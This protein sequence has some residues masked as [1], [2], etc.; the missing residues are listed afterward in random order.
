MLPE[1]LNMELA[2]DYGIIPFEVATHLNWRCQCGWAYVIDQKRTHR[3][4]SNPCCPYHMAERAVEIYKKF[5]YKGIGP[6]TCLNYIL[7]NKLTSHFDLLDESLYLN[8][9]SVIGQSM[10]KYAR[11][12]RNVYL[13]DI[14]ELA[15]IPGIQSSASES[16]TGYSSFE[17]YFSRN[18]S[19]KEYAPMLVS[20]QKYFKICP[21]A[22]RRI[23][24]RATG[25][26]KGYPRRQLFFDY[27]NQLYGNR[28]FVDYKESW[29]NKCD[30]LVCDN[31]TEMTPKLTKALALGI[32]VYTS[33]DFLIG[34]QHTYGMC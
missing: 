24:V 10:L 6:A 2:V 20:A 5:N 7:I 27:V 19:F 15:S 14:V 21:V 18:N 34:M 33:S 29:T 17:E 25:S 4:C 32:P 30:A 16:F 8:D 23:V 26:L 31:Q 1:W 22:G 28:V 11:Q 3:K 9:I 13:H 12:E